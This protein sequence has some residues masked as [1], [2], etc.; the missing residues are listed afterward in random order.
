MMNC[1]NTIQCHDSRQKDNTMVHIVSLKNEMFET[2]LKQKNL[3]LS[4]KLNR[5]RIFLKK[6]CANRNALAQLLHNI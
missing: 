1:N 3:K 5:T 6:N 4:S 2:G